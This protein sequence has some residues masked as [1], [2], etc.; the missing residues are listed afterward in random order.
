VF[1]GPVDNDDQFVKLIGFCK[2]VVGTVL[3]GFDSRFYGCLSGEHYDGRRSR[4]CPELFHHRDPVHN[5]HHDIKKHDVVDG[6]FCAFKGGL[7]VSSN[8]Y[9]KAFSREFLVQ[10]PSERLFVINNEDLNLGQTLQAAE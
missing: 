10:E 9:G 3:H 5:R 4:V 7:P 1:I 6:L 2:I 8:V